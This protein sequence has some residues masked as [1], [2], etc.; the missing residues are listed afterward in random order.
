MKMIELHSHSEEETQA[1]AR[2]IA[3]KCIGGEIIALNG[4]LGAGKTCFTRGLAEGVNAETKEVQSPTFVLQRI[5]KGRINIYHYDAY[6]LNSA[7]SFWELGVDDTLGVDGI[8]VIEWASRIEDALPDEFLEIVFSVVSEHE[9]KITLR[10]H[11]EHYISLLV[12]R[13]I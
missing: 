4:T 1:I 8:S 11:G 9:R 6:R 5:Y 13:S 3:K 10:A 2:E 12:E 7:E